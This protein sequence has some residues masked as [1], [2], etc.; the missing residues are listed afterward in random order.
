MVSPALRAIVGHVVGRLAAAVVEEA[1]ARFALGHIVGAALRARAPDGDAA[2]LEDIAA[3][4]QR[5]VSD[6]RRW[7][8]IAAAIR[9]EEF[10]WLT[11]LR[12]P[13]GMPLTWSHIE[14]LSRVRPLRLRREV[15]REASIQ[16]L[17]VRRL[18]SRVRELRRRRRPTAA[19]TR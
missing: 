5:D 4:L 16:D 3:S 15:A 14:A 19:A 7:A 1:H 11:S 18:Q 13:R 9:A 12:T 8:R 17:S 6:L 10:A 2:R